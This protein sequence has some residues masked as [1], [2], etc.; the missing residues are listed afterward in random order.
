M[1]NVSFILC[2]CLAGGCFTTQELAIGAFD[3]DNPPPSHENVYPDAGL[4]EAPP[5]E[6]AQDAEAALPVDASRLP[7]RSADDDAHE[8]DDSHEST[9]DAGLDG[10]ALG[11]ADAAVA[12]DAGAD[13]GSDTGVVVDA[14][15]DAG[16]AASGVADAGDSGADAGSLL[17]M[18]E[19]W[20][21]L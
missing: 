8:G 3:P 1:R 4:D 2:A 5:S 21:C 17:C 15:T 12:L 16:D 11:S 19:F 20:H 10:G 9:S 7:I 18:I 6:D 14:G 13:A